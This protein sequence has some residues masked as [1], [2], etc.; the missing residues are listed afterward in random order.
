MHQQF[1]HASLQVFSPSDT[2]Q[3]KS[4]HLAK[5]NTYM[6]TKKYFEEQKDKLLHPPGIELKND[7]LES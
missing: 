4:F 1:F 2:S 5:I 7:E 6:N 3:E